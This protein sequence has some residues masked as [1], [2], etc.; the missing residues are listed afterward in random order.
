[1]S[2]FSPTVVPFYK[3]P[4][5]SIRTSI[6]QPSALPS[7]QA[8]IACVGHRSLIDDETALSPLTPSPGYPQLQYYQPFVMPPLG[9]GYEALSYMQ[10]LGFTVNYGLSGTILFP[11]PSSVVVNANSTV[12]LTYASQPL[13]YNLLLQT[14][15]SATITQTTSAATGIFL[16]A[17]TSN[18]SI[19]LGS[20][21][22]TFVT[23]VADTISLA[24][25]NNNLGLPDPNRTEEI[26]MQ[27]FYMYQVMNDIAGGTQ[28]NFI[29]PSVF[30]SVLT[31]RETSG[32][33]APN[34]TPLSLGVPDATAIQTN[35][36]VYV[37][38]DAV[39]ANS[40]YVPLS[41]LGNSA[42]HQATSLASG[43][44]I[45]VLAPFT[46]A[47]CAFVVN[48]GPVTGT[49]NTTNIV[50]LILDASQTVFTQ[51]DSVP[52]T[53]IVNPYNVATNTDISTNQ[54]QFF[55]YI[56]SVNQPT[57]VEKGHYG[58][59]GVFA[60]TT[61]L[62]Q[63]AGSS[64]PTNVN[65]NW[66]A[67]VY[68]PYVPNVGEYPQTAA[69]IA[70]ATAA[71]FSCNSAPYNP[72]SLLV[73]PSVLSSANTQNRVSYGLTGTSSSEVVL[74]LGWSPLCVNAAGNVF[75]ARLITGQTTLPGTNVVD[76]EFFPL[77]T[78]QIV[79]YF[80]QQLYVAL[81]TAGVKQ[82]R[83][84]P[85]VLT[86]IKGVVVG[87]MQNFQTLGM[88]ENVAALAKLVTVTQSNIP[89]TIIIQV[90]VTVIPELASANV[91]VGLISSLF[92]LGA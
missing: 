61:I 19:T 80:Q 60:N 59:F 23:T 45:S 74:D 81:I 92:T 3:T 50:S 28:Y 18:F 40:A 11:A 21:T 67:P 29:T 39:P 14:G 46:I 52:F 55:S 88:F 82:L 83:Q 22:G 75:P 8:T 90:P 66:Y 1:M 35:G 65:S 4:N 24:Y 84:S 77:T 34:S 20:V 51:M 15:F 7:V 64:L 54:S 33:F 37:G 47:G 62:A 87:T 25:I 71:F 72:Q 86:R 63:S 43:T 57:E 53:C 9:S 16:S 38:W 70:A 31:N 56:A 79:T 42:L 89:D 13:N 76:V 27:V 10:N 26:C 5:V 78:W 6:L 32:S 73:I 85:Q 17:S 48:L 58:V 91:Q 44:I 2:A 69:M 30:L 41:S 49:F 68:Y 36:D 12:T